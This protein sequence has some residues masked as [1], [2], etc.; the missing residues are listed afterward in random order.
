[1]KKPLSASRKLLG[2]SEAYA[3]K[4]RVTKPMRSFNEIRT[5]NWE[6]GCRKWERNR[7]K[8]VAEHPGQVYPKG[9]P[10]EPEK[11]RETASGKHYSFLILPFLFTL[12]YLFAL[13]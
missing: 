2:L 6:A 4:D 1:M 11:R 3:P 9:K 8:W 5:A 12:C 10:K 7:K 13:L